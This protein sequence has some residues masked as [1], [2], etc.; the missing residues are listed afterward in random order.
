MIPSSDTLLSQAPSG[1]DIYSTKS[2]VPQDLDGEVLAQMRAPLE[3][4][5]ST[6]LAV[7]DS[8]AEEDNETVKPPGSYPGGHTLESGEGSYY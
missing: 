7:N 5:N 8:S 1:R 2:F 4:D 3:P 6:H